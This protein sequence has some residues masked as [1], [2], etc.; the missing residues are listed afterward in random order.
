MVTLPPTFTQWST[1]SPYDASSFLSPPL[2][3]TPGLLAAPFNQLVST[4]YSGSAPTNG[5]LFAESGCKPPP[6]PAGGRGERASTVPTDSANPNHTDPSPSSLIKRRKPSQAQSESIEFIQYRPGAGAGDKLSKKR[7]ASDEETSRRSVSKTLVQKHLLDRNGDIQGSLI[8]MGRRSTMRKPFTEQ[9]RLETARARKEGVCDRCKRSKR[10]CNLAQNYSPYEPCSLCAGSRTYKGV[11]RMPCSR[12]D[13]KDV[14]LFRKGPAPNEPLYTPRLLHDLADLADLS[15]RN[16]E[17]RTLHL[18][19]KLGGHRLTVYAS[20]FCPLPNDVVSY[21]WKDYQ[22][23]GQE[24]LMPNF[25][26]TNITKVTDQFRDYITSAKRQYLDSLR[27]E[28]ELAWMTVD[29]AVRYAKRKPDSLVAIALDLWAVSRMIEIPWE[30]C[31]NDTLGVEQIQDPANPHHGKIPIPPIMDT[32][33]DQIVIQAVLVPMRDELV[34]KFDK[35]TAPP[36]PGAWFETYLTAFILLNHIERLAK[37]SVF[38]A[39]LHTMRTKY[40]NKEFLEGAFHTA[41]I[42]LSRFHFVCNGS[43]PLKLD[44][45]LPTTISMAKLEPEQVAFMERTQEIIRERENNIRS[46]QATNNYERCL[47]WSHQ[48]FFEKWDSTPARVVDVY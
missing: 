3:V 32:Q 8:T 13:I 43:A 4:E 46:L 27:S 47:Y 24:M 18:T 40:S 22:G 39:R 17:V 41:K 42:I 37:H 9:K 19:Q 35:I 25:C 30:M 5:I 10:K 31:G 48:L 26:L 6:S 7:P 12:S 15:A 21:K 2:G 45:K 33:L 34:E 29:M 11:P 36:K 16:V 1:S 28:D 23:N 20:E 38:H 14:S 44:W